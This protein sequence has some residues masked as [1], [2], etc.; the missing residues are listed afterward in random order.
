MVSNKK[1]NKA[2]IIK[3]NSVNNKNISDLTNALYNN[4]EHLNKNIINTSKY[5]AKNKPHDNILIPKRPF[6]HSFSIK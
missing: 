1:V 3:F 5:S 6:Q 2:S 4:E